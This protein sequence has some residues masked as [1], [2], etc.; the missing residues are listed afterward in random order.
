VKAKSEVL[1]KFLR[2]KGGRIVSDYDGSPWTVGRW[3]KV[4]APTEECIGLNASV[5][6]VEALAYVPGDVIAQVEVGGVIIKGDDKW[7]CERM[8]IIKWCPW[9]KRMSVKLAVYSARMVLDKFEVKYPDDNRP[10][11]AIETSEAWLK[12]KTK[13]ERDGL[14]DACR[15][16][17]IAAAECSAADSAYSAAESAAWSAWSSARAWSAANADISRYMLSLCRWRKGGKA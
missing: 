6:A 5:Y 17:G 4:P 13:K 15:S 8:R 1:Y 7:T 10:R 16:V 14:A 2:L 12:A 11:K 9:T 3:R